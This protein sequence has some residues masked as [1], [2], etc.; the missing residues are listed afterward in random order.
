MIIQS[1]DHG[2][3]T[4]DPRRRWPALLLFVP[5][6]GQ[7]PRLLGLVQHRYRPTAV[8]RSEVRR[9]KPASVISPPS[10]EHPRLHLR[11][12]TCQR[13]RQR[14]TRHNRHREWYFLQNRRRKAQTRGQKPEVRTDLQLPIPERRDPC[15]HTSNVN[16]ARQSISHFSGK[17]LR[18]CCLHCDGRKG[19][20]VGFVVRLIHIRGEKEWDLARYDTAHG[21]PH[22]DLLTREGKVKEKRWIEGLSFGQALNL[23]IEDFRQNHEKYVDEN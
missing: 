21:L 23:A 11:P 7:R 2:L 18:D 19:R 20:V 15:C 10:S 4:L 14:D 17:G 22:L 12:R 6:P 9:L 1:L 16:H 5:F 13:R 3:S 8:Q